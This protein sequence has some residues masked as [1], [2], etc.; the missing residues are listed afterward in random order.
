[1]NQQFFLTLVTTTI[2]VSIL[3]LP[4]QAEWEYTRW[5]MSVDEVVAASEGAAITVN[6]NEQI[7]LKTDTQQTL[8]KSQWS[9]D[10][11]SF[12]V[13]FNF[14]INSV[15]DYQLSEI[16]FKSTGNNED[17]GLAMIEEFGLPSRA[18]GGLSKKDS[19]I[20]GFRLVERD[21]YAVPETEDIWRNQ[22]ERTDEDIVVLLEWNTARNFI[23]MSRQGTD[24]VII[25]VKPAKR[26]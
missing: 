12:D 2:F 4:A 19:D 13:F 23:Q 7:L 11:Y 17:L 15:N 1:M 3:N 16:I 5:G 10:G 18:Q 9:K 25:R 21:N 6:L 22:P 14:S 20:R 8:L 26:R 24:D